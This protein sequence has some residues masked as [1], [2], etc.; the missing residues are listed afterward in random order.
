LRKSGFAGRFIAKG[1]FERRMQAIPVKL[2][3]HEQP[4]LVGAAA[5]F[6]AQ[7]G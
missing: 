1:R 4:G 7:F 2:L 6:A 3:T 5:A